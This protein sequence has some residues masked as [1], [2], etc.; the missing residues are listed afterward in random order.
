M[1]SKFFS[2]V[3]GVS[4]VV[5]SSMISLPAAAWPGSATQATSASI[6]AKQA[7]QKN[8]SCS[9]SCTKYLRHDSK[10]EIVVLNEH[11]KIYTIRRVKLPQ[12]AELASFER[13]V[14]A[15]PTRTFITT[16]PEE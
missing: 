2:F 5:L 6:S 1:K 16:L 8:N 15:V 14:P 9:A 10:L 13:I 12:N 4:I 7:L 3:G 11:G